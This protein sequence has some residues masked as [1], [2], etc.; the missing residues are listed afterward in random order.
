MEQ[1]NKKILQTLEFN[2]I[3]QAVVNLAASDLGKE[4]VLSLAPSINKEEVESWQDET[5]DGTK[6]LKLRGRMPIPKLQ[7][8]RPHLKRLDIGAS[9]NGLEIA[10]IGKILRTTSEINRFFRKIKRIWN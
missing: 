3:I 9:L 2:K 1:M 5:E 7:N 4:H 8:V 10:Q 6:I